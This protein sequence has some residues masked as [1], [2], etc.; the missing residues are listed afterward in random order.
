MY[1]IKDKNAFNVKFRA[2]QGL[3][4]RTKQ[5]LLKEWGDE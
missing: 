2:I 1:Y 5:V 4:K 3:E